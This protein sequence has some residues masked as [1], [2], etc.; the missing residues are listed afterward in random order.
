[1]RTAELSG[2]G[3][4]NLRIVERPPPRPGHGEVRVRV[5]AVS[6]NYRDVLLVRG[7]YN[8]R[9]AFPVVPCSDAAG[10]VDAVGPG[11]SAWQPGDRVVNS[12]F[13]GW[14]AGGPTPAALASGLGSPGDGVLAEYRVFPADALVRTP[15]HLSDA[16]AATF[17]CAGVT[18]WS[19][20]VALGG[21][22]PGDTVLVQGTGGVS[23][24]ALQFAKL[25]GARVVATSSS[26]EKLARA[27]AL[28]ADHGINYT[29]VPDWGAAAR[30][31]AGGSGL[32]HIVEVGGAGTLEQSVR[33]IRPGGTIS[34]I[35][36]LS[37]PAPMLNL[38]LVVMRQVR[39]QG[40]TVGPTSELEAML[41]AVAQWRLRPVVG[42]Q[43]PLDHLHDA[44][45]LMDRGGHFGKVVVTL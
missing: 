30:A 3:L 42:A 6:L 17:P 13:P 29:A 33:A 20:I 28:G 31:W 24:F 10:E 23:V 5:R 34:L 12:F 45:R 27:A 40:V 21:T 11:V 16:E 39:L 7:V 9:Q 35:G 19:A 38:P 22:R 8:P 4:E 36:V 26:D 15:D 43:V 18:A 1:M 37:G 14:P 41:R 44:F 2:F 32:D 25:C